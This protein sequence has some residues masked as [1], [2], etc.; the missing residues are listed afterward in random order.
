MRKIFE[1]RLIALLLALVMLISVL[2]LQVFAEEAGE[3]NLTDAPEKPVSDEA[4]EE[5]DGKFAIGDI[6]S[7]I[8]FDVSPAADCSHKVVEDE[9]IPAMC[10]DSGLTAGSH[11]ELCGQVFVAQ[12]VIPALGHDIMQID[13]KLPSYGSVGWEAYEKCSR[14][15][16][17]TYVEIP[18]LPVP[19]IEDYETFIMNLMLLEQ[20]AYEY[21]MMNPGKD[22]TQLVIK[23]I[24]TG[25]DRYNSGS[26]GIMAGYEDAGFATF[27]QQ[28]QDMFNTEATSEE[29]MLSITSLKEIKNFYMP[30][31]DYVDVGHM[32]GTMDITYHNNFGSNHAD[33]AGWAGDLVDLLSLSD[34]LGTGDAKTVEEMVVY[35]G[36]K[37]FL[38]SEKDLVENFGEEPKEGSFSLTDLYGDL[39]GY[40]FCK[41]LASMEYETGILSNLMMEY[42]TE[43]LTMEQRLEYFMENRLDGFSTRS[44]LRTVVYNAYTSNRVIATLEGTREFEAS[45]ISDMRR[46][47]CYAF[48]DY[49]CRM[50]GDYVDVV[51]NP[52]YTV[53]S[54]ETAVLAPG[55][56]QNIKL[57]STADGKQIA[58][59]IA[60]A[61]LTRDDVEVYAN[62]NNNDPT[63]GWAM[64]RVLDQANAAQEK[65]GNPESEYYIENY[66]VIA[67]INGDGYNMATGKPG[68]L[69]VMNGVEYHPIDGNGFFGILKDGTP[70]IGS[71]K[72]YETIYK[73]QVRDGI[74]AFGTTLV[75]NGEVVITATSN[76][77]TDRASRTSVGITSTG[78]VVFMVLDGRQEPFSCG[79]SMLEIAQI[80]QEA[81]CVHA[82]N[83][84]GG[85]STTFVAKQPGE[86]ELRVI[87]NPSDGF[88][89]SVA[90]TLM[91]VSTAPSST[92]FDH[93]VLEMDTS[94]LTVGSSVQIKASGVS[95]TGNA[96]ELPEG[97]TWEVSNSKWG[98]ITEDGVF[99]ALR[100]G[101]VEVYLMLDGQPLASKT[102]NIVIP[103]SV[104]FT[105]D[106]VNAVYGQS[107]ELPIKAQYEGKDMAI[108]AADVSFSISNNQAGSMD[109]F[110]FV[111]AAS[112]AVKNVKITAS[113]VA[114][115]DAAPASISVALY[116]QGEI[117]FDFDQAIG[118]DRKLAWDRVV[119]NAT[120][121][122]N[123]TYEVID[124]EKDMVTSYTLAIDMSQIPFPEQL[125][126]LIYML[127]GADAEDASAWGFLMQLAERISVLTEVRPMIRF[128]PNVDVD[129]SNLKLVND[130]FTL[131]ETT[132]DPETN[133]LSLTLNWIDQ[134]A[135][136]PPET[137]NP[138]CI[139][140]GLKITPKKDAEWNSKN[141]LNIVN[142]GEIG[143]EIYMRANALYS[144]A[145]KPE[146]QEIYGILPFVN[147]DLPSEKG[148]CFS[149]I[150]NTF[151][152]EYTLVNQLKNGWHNVDGGYAYYEN[153]KRYTGICKAEG[154]Y[155]DFGTDGVNVGKNPYT[156]IFEEKGYLYYSR[157]GELTSGWFA[158][159]GSY[160]YFNPTTFRAHTGVSRIGNQ[161]Y[162]FGEDGKLLK[163]A[164]VETPKGLRYYWAGTV[165]ARA[166]IETDEGKLFA[167]DAGY[168]TYGNY[169]VRGNATED[170]IW[171]HFDEETGILT[172]VCDGFLEYNGV[173]Y[174][175]EDGVWFYGAVV[176]DGGIV[177]CGSNGAVRKNGS[178]YVS[179]SMDSTAGL[180]PGYYWCGA[181]GYILAN[182]FATINGA[183]YYFIDY[184]RAKGLT[185]IGEDYY[186]FNA[187]T[188]KMYTNVSLWVSGSNP[189]GLPSGYYDFMADGRMYVPNPDGE[190]RIVEENGKL[191]FTIDGMKQKNGLNEL[192]GE[193]YYASASGVLARNE[194]VWVSQR[195][196]LI[197][198]SNG[199]FGFDNEGKMIKTGFVTSGDSTFYY[200]NIVRAKGLKKIGENYY[201]FNA[202]SGKMY[203]NKA[204]WISSNNPYGLPSGY[205]DFMADGRMY[206][207]DPNG[208]KAVIEEGGKLYFTIDGMKQRNGLNEMDGEYYYAQTSGVLAR[209]ETIWVGQRNGLIE[210]TNGYYA[211]DGNGRL[212]KTGFAVSANGT[213]YYNNIVRVKGF[214]K[215]GDDYYY[216]NAGSGKMYADT[217][218]WVGTNPYGLEKGYYNFM[219]DGKMYI[220]DPNGEKAIIEENGNLYFTIDGV[221]QRN[222]LNE[223]NGQYYYAQSSGILARSESIWVS[224]RNGLIEETN[225]YFAFD[226]RGRL[227]KTGFATGGGD[228]YYY[229]NL[230]RV[231][232]F[233]KIGRDYYMFNSSSGKMGCD[234]TLYVGDNIYGI[235]KGYYYFGTNGK[236]V[237]D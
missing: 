202:G 48:A 149:S 81:G 220:P 115:S 148:G 198:E 95:A 34:Q 221:K 84:D 24:R 23:Y 103:T 174:Y 52:Y 30:N 100:N 1:K 35:I 65:Y 156:G 138:L 17:S 231:K 46:A 130:Y 196:G 128:D 117:S 227:V 165:M 133:T 79:G 44:E 5:S 88:A 217:A 137:A 93:A 16:Y 27:V 73:D 153:G 204:L 18:A 59:Y 155:Y 94:Y 55:I 208:E 37:Y 177:F 118:G 63:Q 139:V 87:S 181:D 104:Y 179:D 25:V 189:Y 134:T 185:K 233:T 194:T 154:L 219:A 145:Q 82:V 186:F 178:C 213:Y 56:T 64:Q 207:P 124:P 176:A 109:G 122:D 121:E 61:D 8:T 183:T 98:T 151:R 57:A 170:A 146:N 162:T 19:P 43:E 26:W 222:G 200:E 232:G 112:A 203:V 50:V 119:S 201:F 205:Y 218:L 236:M 33:V 86:D 160:Y 72:D 140:S 180:E 70:V 102:M 161:T 228:T 90:T 135:A 209:N 101:N 60:M 214:T 21:A 42:F 69:L 184:A 129:Y 96:V 158:V 20:F 67:S 29:E 106:S 66:N 226:S 125:N 47:C 123:K 68:G 110:T 113:L 197:R 11:C 215:I 76:Y 3:P 92:A 77:Y 164:F 152:D 223:L 54:S 99:T 4:T 116:N 225:G 39:D 74:G 13:A 97:V 45:D 114:N 167:N 10:E 6:I 136:I 107:V 182:G 142:Y 75:L 199:Y 193:Y 49:I 188:G 190:R 91:M 78:K 235:A 166:W 192:D 171:M 191:Y 126:D 206:I 212:V 169:P 32:F 9:E 132:F 211:F 51:G 40:Y 12:Q 105:K 80:M 216:F 108:N 163:G 127:P 147:P 234:V 71:K 41:R 83:L 36:E 131:K 175:C 187:G 28:M 230:V 31:G 173:T 229:R 224:Q 53:F 157:L 89:R 195:N 159:M 150:Y 144:F 15:H 38:T 58:Y 168:I 210:E 2:P 7:E 172:G 141:R 62:Y 14:C 85:G 22:P 143:Y 111:T 237:L 120:T